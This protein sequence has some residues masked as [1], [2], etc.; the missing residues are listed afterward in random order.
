MPLSWAAVQLA[1][2]WGVPSL[3][4]GSV[5]SDASEIGWQLGMKAGLGAATIPLAGGDVCG[6]LGLLDSS[7]VLYPEKLILD[8]EICQSAYEQFHGFPFDEK[9]MALDVIASVGPRGHFLKQQHTRRHIRDFRLPALLRQ[10]G[11]GG[12]RRS[13]QDIA[14]DEFRRIN[15]SHHPQPLP[16][17]VLAEL[18][19]I[20]ASAEREAGQ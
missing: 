2:A 15:A 18:D 10:K 13:P 9:G 3:G 5:S 17:A 12:K 7:M 4:G 16:K 19:Q 8:V 6:D 20:L 1:H 11:P 14:L